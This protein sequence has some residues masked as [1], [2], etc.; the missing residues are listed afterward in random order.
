MAAKKL[1]ILCFI[2]SDPRLFTLCSLGL[3]LHQA[4]EV[5]YRRQRKERQEKFCHKGALVE[6]ICMVSGK[7]TCFLVRRGFAKGLDRPGML[8][9]L[10]QAQAMGLIHVTDNVCEQPSFL[11]NCC[12]CCCELMAG[13]QLVLCRRYSQDAVSCRDLGLLRRISE[14]LQRQVHRPSRQIQCRA[15]I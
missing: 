4:D 7:G 2:G 9:K 1:S 11:C 12:R 14:D 15:R 3:G 5:S 10:Q 8:A 6:D 13:V